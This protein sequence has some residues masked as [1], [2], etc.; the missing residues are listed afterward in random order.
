MRELDS[1]Q[2]S[3]SPDPES[4]ASATC[5]AGM[6]DLALERE[7]LVRE[8]AVARDDDRVD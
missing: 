1:K 4:V 2:S 7:F 3:R 6:G 8:I 5:F